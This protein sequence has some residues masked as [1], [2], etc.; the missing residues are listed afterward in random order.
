MLYTS[1][2][3]VSIANM[4]LVLEKLKS[5]YNSKGLLESVLGVAAYVLFYVLPIVNI[6]IYF[7]ILNTKMTGLHFRWVANGCKN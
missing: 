7:F 4:W 5:A 2:K 3:N 1:T 6:G